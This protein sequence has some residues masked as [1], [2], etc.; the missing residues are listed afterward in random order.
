MLVLFQLPENNFM[1]KHIMFIRRYT[2][3]EKLDN[4]SQVFCF[5]R[6]KL[7]ITEDNPGNTLPAFREVLSMNPDLSKW[8]YLGEYNGI[9][10]VCVGVDEGAIL[11]ESSEF[12]DL[13][14]LYSFLGIELWR[15]AGYARQIVDWGIN[16]R[17]CGRCGH[18]TSSIEGETAKVCDRCGIISYPRI[19]PA[20]IVAVINGD[21]ILLARGKRFKGPFYSV[22][23]GFVSPGESL[24]ECV[25]REVR[26]E[27]GVE[28]ENIRYFNSQSW[29]FPDSLMIGFFADYRSG[30]IKIDPDEIVDAGWFTTDNLTKMKIPPEISIAR[31]MIDEFRSNSTPEG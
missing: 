8:H 21:K 29:P 22:L 9:P 20:M 15:L 18:E 6:G 1:R 23:A 28:I 24:E 26:E 5:N 4:N 30:A 7:L 12:C 10:C 16:F 17:Y 11:P 14:Q 13:W 19:S 25:V 3:P 27:V 2:F 31:N